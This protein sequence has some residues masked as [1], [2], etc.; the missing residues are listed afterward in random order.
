M[1]IAYLL[2]W[3]LI[4]VIPEKLAYLLANKI[5]DYLYKKNGKGVKRLRSNYARVQPLMSEIE[6]NN[7]TKAGMRSY[8]RYWIDTFRLNTWSKERITS[9]TTVVNEELLRNPIASKQGCLVVLPHAGNWDHAA[10]Y[11][12][13]TGINLT[14]VA[15]KLKP[16][17]IFLK[18]LDYRQSIGIEVL[19]TE[20]KVMPILLDRL[21][22]GKLVALVADRDLS[23]NGLSVD[24]FGG[25]AK[26]PSGPARLII[27]SNSAFVSAFITYSELGI[28]IE[29]KSI[30]PIPTEGSVEERVQK[31][32]QLMANNFAAGI[33]SSTVDW[34]ML[35]RIWTDE[36]I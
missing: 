1:Y 16:E 6:L 14:T 23:K 21:R 33:K 30:G 31:L 17:Q 18:F 20:E 13:S 8:L 24:F 12:C 9:T 28:N 4:G 7:L 15:E 5:A 10:A 36:K 27:D 32:T 3:R 35:Q 11:F 2:A 22:S 19:H 29:F 25:I 26:M 34:H